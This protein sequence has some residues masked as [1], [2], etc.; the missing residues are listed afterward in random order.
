MAVALLRD[1]PEEQQLEHDSQGNTVRSSQPAAAFTF[2][3]HHV[4][5]FMMV[6][7]SSLSYAMM[8]TVHRTLTSRA[9]GRC[10]MWQPCGDSWRLQSVYSASA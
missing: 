4:Q 2:S 9:A 1:V 5:H 6:H 10:C 3:S 7:Q 8:L